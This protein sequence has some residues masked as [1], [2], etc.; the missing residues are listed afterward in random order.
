MGKNFAVQRIAVGIHRHHGG[1]IHDLQFPD[2]LGRTELLQQEVKLMPLTG[3]QL[4]YFRDNAWTNPLSS[5]GAGTADNL[6]K[7]PDAVQLLLQ[8]N[9]KDKLVLDWVRPSF[10][11]KQ[12]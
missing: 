12:P 3:W 4:F 6:L 5:S 8:L 11:A 9:T 1:E 2:R 7:S 10:G